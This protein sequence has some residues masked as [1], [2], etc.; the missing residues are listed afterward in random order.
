MHRRPARLLS[1]V[2]ALAACSATA[3]AAQDDGPLQTLPVGQYQCSLPGDAAGSAW[4]P[5][6]GKIFTIKNAS[7][8][9]SPEG[10]GIYLMTG[11]ELVFTRGPMKN[12]RFKRMGSSILRMKEADGSLGRVRCVRVG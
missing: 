4:V 1:A 3:S 6:E 10:S 12:Q 11:D 9:L 5:I 7:R 8:Y 2:I